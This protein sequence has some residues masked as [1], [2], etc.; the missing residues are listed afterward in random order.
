MQIWNDYIE[1]NKDRFIEELKELLSVPSI[2]T[3][4]EYKGQ[5]HQCAALVAKMM[6]AAGCDMTEVHETKKHPVV[7]GKKIIDV[8]KRTV[9]VYGHYDVQPPDPIELWHNDP[10]TPTVR[11]GKIIARGSSDDKGQMFIHIK[12]LETL[13]QTNTLPC[14]IKF[15]IEGEEEIGSASLPDYLNN[16]KEDLKADIVLVSDTAMISMEHPSIETALRGM[17]YMQVEVTGPNRDLHSGVY[18]GAVANPIIVLCELIAS[19][20]DKNNKIAIKGFYDKVKELPESERKRISKIPFDEKEY[21]HELG[22]EELW[23]EKG[24]S[25]MERTGTRPSLD[26]NGI[27]G[28]Y[29]GIGAKTVLPSKAYA[30]ISMRIVPDQ[31]PDEIADLFKQH[32]LNMCPASVKIDVE[33][34]HG[35]M[36]ATT[37]TNSKGYKAAVKAIQKTFDKEPYPVYSGGSIPVVGLFK[38]LLGLDTVLLGFGL[39]TDN[40]HSPN[41][42]LDVFNFL[43]GIET[44]LYFHNFFSDQ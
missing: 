3:D 31:Q 36:P 10:F 35:G 30:K 2:S 6:M 23:G 8:N 28:G 13:I 37:P 32:L 42:K 41:E 11:D 22:I 27:W 24:Y 40:I 38:H 29:T 15:I 33:L 14:N 20:H 16:H 7:F 17:A 44:T 34:L 43:K 9:L 25:T 26:V 5:M 19:L 1:K 4:E 12:V 21:K 39:D 18:G